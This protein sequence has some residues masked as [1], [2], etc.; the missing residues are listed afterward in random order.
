MLQPAGSFLKQRVIQL[1]RFVTII[2]LTY[3]LVLIATKSKLRNISPFTTAQMHTS[4]K[5][6][7]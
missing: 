2:A 1:F 4:K 5:R 7:N 3:I 6:Q